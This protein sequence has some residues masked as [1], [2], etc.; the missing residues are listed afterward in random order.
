[1]ASTATV[2]W[3]GATYSLL[4]GH[5]SNDRASVLLQRFIVGLILLNGVAVILESNHQLNA[6][7]GWLFS[8]F[9]LFSV[10]IFTLEYLGRVWVAV[11]SEGYA[12]MSPWRARLRYILSPMAL[13]DLLA[14]APF[15]LALFIAI[16]L[17]YLRFFRLLRLLKLSH[18][19][20][21]LRIFSEVIRREAT[22]I[23]AALLTMLVL[24]IV[25][26]CLM[27]SVEN[28]AR[29]GH[30]ESITQAIWW[31]VVTLT[32]VGYGDITPITFAGKLLA[33]VIMML[34]IGTMA[35]P[36]GI[37][38][39]RFSEELNS[40]REYVSRRVA[41]AYLDG[42][43]DD[44]E[45]EA[46]RRLQKELGLSREIVDRMV[47]SQRHLARQTRFCSHCGERVE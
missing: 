15:Y 34:G 21:G 7:Y 23:A 8:L 16:D 11:E 41:T 40:R 9:E 31:A 35:L 1:M 45:E 13:I 4:E 5:V 46:V 14:I 42:V 17:R 47:S 27:F 43:F 26:A 2:T 29:P 20:D 33:M 28:A 12:D 19:F 38:A 22:A 6:S 32:T 24:I 10:A 44:D 39:E 25:S 3:R 18:Y 30:F 37:L 36:A